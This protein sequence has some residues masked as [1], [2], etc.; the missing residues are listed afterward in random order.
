MRDTAAHLLAVVDRCTPLL[1][2]IPPADAA[3]RPAPGKWSKQEILGHLI[4]SAGNNQQKFVRLL[5]ATAPIDFPGYAQDAWVEQ[6]HY[7]DADWPSLVSLWR[8]CNQ[9][10][11]HVIA[12]AAPERLANTI[13]ID[14]AGPFRLDFVMRDYVEHQKH[15]LLQILP[16]AGLSQRLRCLIPMRPRP[17]QLPTSPPPHAAQRA[18]P[19]PR[20]CL[21]CANGCARRRSPI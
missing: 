12:H 11:A 20:C 5:T 7:R 18:T 14:G 8:A 4:D 15:H 6:Q 3:R 17:R 19:P 10:L 1:L 9:H 16:D 2:A 13:R 21:Q